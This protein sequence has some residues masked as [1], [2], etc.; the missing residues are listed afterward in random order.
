[1]AKNKSKNAAPE[2]A[3][4]AP[5]D[6]EPPAVAAPEVAPEPTKAKAKGASEVYRPADF[7]YQDGEPITD[8][9]HLNLIG[10]PK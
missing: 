8:I 3:P 10:K 4:Q 7:G 1:M 6:P 9:H 5:T 2:V